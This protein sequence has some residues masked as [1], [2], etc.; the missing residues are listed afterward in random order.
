MAGPVANVIGVLS[1]VIDLLTDEVSGCA[2]VPLPCRSSVETGTTVAWDHCKD[3][4]CGD[5]DGQLW[6]SLTALT[7]VGA[8]SEAECVSLQWTA[9]I[10][11]V[12]CAKADIGD[13]G[14][15]PTAV[16]LREDVDQQA[17][18]AD[19]IRYALSCCTARGDSLR[20]VALVS[21]IPLGP[22]G[23]C[24]GGQWTVRG[25]LDVCC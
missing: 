2:L 13:D 1:H 19:A 6:A 14:T 11:I 23:G 21:W 3:S 7:A 24:V 9:Q 17:L 12:R 4:A 8:S 16:Q 22:S 15:M 10:G 18:D 20:D 5:R 25:V